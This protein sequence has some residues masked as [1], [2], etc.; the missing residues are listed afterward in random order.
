[1]PGIHG[2]RVLLATSTLVA[3]M[4]LLPQAHATTITDPANDLIPSYVGPAN[5][6][7]DV[8]STSAAVNATTL[9]LNAT[10]NGPLGT[11][12]GAT[13]VFGIDRGAGTARFGALASGVTFDA[14]VTATASGVGAG[15]DLIANTPFSLDAGSV[16]VS[17]NHISVQVPLSLLPTEGF[18]VSAYLVNL[19]PRVGAGNSG[20]SDFAPDNSDFVVSAVPEPGSLAVIAAGIAAIGMLNL[21]RRRA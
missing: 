2:F 6:D 7:M 3:A 11:T 10:L 4:I 9:F 5:G 13:Y 19:W 8:L 21:R 17:G 1:M 18:A 14:V 15:R 16:I 12:A 20:I